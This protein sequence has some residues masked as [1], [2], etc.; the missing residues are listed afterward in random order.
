[1]WLR[2]GTYTYE[3][4]VTP[5]GIPG[6][7]NTAFS[8]LGF[9]PAAHAV[10]YSFSDAAAAGAVNA[11]SAFSII[12]EDDGTI[13]W[14]VRTLELIS[15]FWSGSQPIRIFFQSSLPPGLGLYNLSASNVGSTMNYAPVPAPEPE[16]PT[17]VEID[18]RPHNAR[19]QIN[20]NRHEHVRV[21]ILSSDTFD[22]TTVDPTTVRFGATGTEAAPITWWPH[23]RPRD[24]SK[25]RDVDRDGD[26][27]MVLLFKVGDTGIKC[28]DTSATLTGQTVDGEDFEGTDAIK[29]PRCPKPKP[30]KKNRHVH[31]EEP[32]DD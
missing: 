1:V 12:L 20:L 27:D 17:T 28:G 32:D 23:R 13:D 11:G 31:E 16:G 26:V 6:E 5:Q 24:R 9:D 10:G 19:N 14:G 2:E 18:I 8:V 21:A 25:L 30:P 4:V 29:T 22:A 7:F 3:L 15:G